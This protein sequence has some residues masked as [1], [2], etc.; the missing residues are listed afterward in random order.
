M[1]CIHLL[2]PILWST[3]TGGSVGL[4][5]YGETPSQRSKVQRN[6]TRHLIS[7][8]GCHTVTCGHSHR[9]H[10]QK[11][12]Q[13]YI[14]TVI[15]GVLLITL[16]LKITVKTLTFNHSRV[17]SQKHH[18]HASPYAR[19]FTSVLG[20]HLKFVWEMFLHL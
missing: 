19:A 1:L 12:I 2:A 4:R 5:V 6:K 7:S 15:P 13:N 11:H 10:T 9:Y 8:S 18:C 3:E 17:V 14:R 20:C 16:W